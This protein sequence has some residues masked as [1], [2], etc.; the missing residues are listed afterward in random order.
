MP[1]HDWTRVDPNDYHHF[2]GRWIYAIAD[3]LN[4]G[5]LPAD[6]FALAE[7]VTPPVIP[8]V[9][10]L[11]APDRRNG[12]P[13]GG[14]QGGAG[15]T[16]QTLTANPPRV[17]F[18]AAG[19]A[20]KPRRSQRRISVR[21]A[22]DRRLVAVIELVSPSNKTKRSETRAFVEKVTRLLRQGVHALVIDPFPPLNRDPIPIHEAIWR[23]LVRKPELPVLDKPLTLA[24]YAAIADEFRTF[25][26]AVGVG[27]T[28]PEM[29]LFLE[30][31]LYI[32]VP[33]ESAYQSA[34]Q[35]YPEYLREQ[36]ER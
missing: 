13:P 22:R 19:T 26:E 16:G 35:T 9:L 23:S 29:P 4:L 30:D 6:Y 8:D 7:H 5:I 21:H 28:L 24:S 11:E 10:T 20:K 34:W 2:H 14:R 18:S 33:L 12:T 15:T 31:D 25:V 3:A 27:D 32:N 36:I 1:I 17:R